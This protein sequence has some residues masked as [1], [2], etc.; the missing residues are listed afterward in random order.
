MPSS[1]NEFLEETL[2]AQVSIPTPQIPKPPVLVGIGGTAVNLASIKLSLA[3]HDPQQI[4][5]APLSLQEIT[6]QIRL[7]RAG[8]IN[9]RLMIPG[10]EARRADVI[11]AGAAI[12]QSIL[13]H[14]GVEQIYVSTRGL[15]Y[16]VMYD[17]FVMHNPTLSH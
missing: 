1:T 7:F 16:G 6:N 17:R 9:D 12:V 13:K 2:S 4:H 3:E 14:V 11:I 10:L 8:T 5:G 15:R